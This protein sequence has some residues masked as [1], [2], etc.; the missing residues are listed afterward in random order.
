MA[1]NW[2]CPDTVH[3]NGLTPMVGLIFCRQYGVPVFVCQSKAANI[4]YYVNS[5]H[6][7]Q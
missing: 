4:C 7:F 2:G 1:E 3:A 5:F 6:K